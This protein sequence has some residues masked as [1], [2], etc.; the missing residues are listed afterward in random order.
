MPLCIASL[1]ANERREIQQWIAACDSGKALN[2]SIH[3]IWEGATRGTGL[4]RRGLV[5]A[6]EQA[7]R[8]WN[9]SD[10]L[11]CDAVALGVLRDNVELHLG[12]S[13][14]QA[15]FAQLYALA[16]AYWAPTPIQL[17]ASEL[18]AELVE[19]WEG[20]WQLPTADVVV[21]HETRRLLHARR[22]RVAIANPRLRWQSLAQSGACAES[23]RTFGE[24]VANLSHELTVLAAKS[25]LRDGLRALRHPACDQRFV[26]AR[27][28]VGFGPSRL[29]ARAQ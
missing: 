1:A 27:R 4:A 9:S 17:N 15:R 29:F 6:V 21:S 12:Q 28:S 26:C 25:A 23:A 19:A 7:I 8:I 18:R 5:A 20:V 11:V 14:R 24:L 13:S 10:S 16:E 22:P 2:C 3:T